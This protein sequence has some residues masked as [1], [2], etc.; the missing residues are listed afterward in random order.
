MMIGSVALVPYSTLETRR[1]AA[2]PREFR[3]PRPRRPASS[4]RA[5]PSRAR[6]TFRPQRHAD[7]DFIGPPG[8]G[9]GHES[10]NSYAGQ[11]CRE[12]AK[13]SRKTRNQVCPAMR[14]IDLLTMV[15]NKRPVGCDPPG[16]WLGGPRQRSA[17]D[18]LC[19]APRN[20]SSI[21]RAGCTDNMPPEMALAQV[22]VFGV[23]HDPNHFE[24]VAVFRITPEP[25]VPPNWRTAGKYHRANV[26][27]MTATLGEAPVS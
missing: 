14:S 5:S 21:G 12:Q 9:I 16:R 3:A 19:G 10:V 15:P 8:N 2:A 25:E 22:L 6:R 4:S 24:V 11:K 1:P 13:E 27:L 20:R 26:S 23:F 17:L 7:T 18:Y